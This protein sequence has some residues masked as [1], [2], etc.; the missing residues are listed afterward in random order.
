[1]NLLEQIQS[2]VPFELYKPQ[3]MFLDTL[4]EDESSVPFE[5]YKPQHW[6]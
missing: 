1:M 4:I 5:L 2:S 6:R 3:Q